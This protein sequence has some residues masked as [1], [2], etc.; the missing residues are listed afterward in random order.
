MANLQQ[1]K[2]HPSVIYN[3]I[4]EQSGSPEKALAELVMNSI[5]AG[6][7]NISIE[8]SS[9]KFKI[10][11]DG[12]G[13]KSL[14]EIETFFGTFGT[15]HQK[16]DAVYGQFRLGRGQSFAIAK[17]EWRSGL[18]GMSVDLICNSK[19]DVHGYSLH[20]FKD[21]LAGCEIEGEF[22]ES[23]HIFAG[24]QNAMVFDKL[25]ESSLDKYI[26]KPEFGIFNSD[27]FFERF[28]QNI[29]LLNN[30]NIT[31]NGKVV[32]GLL[33]TKNKVIKETETANYYLSNSNK[34]AIV[35]LNKGI[36]IGTLEFFVP[37]VI[38]F[39][40]SPNLNIA[41][42]QINAECPIYRNGR[43]E[44]Y[45]AIFEAWLNG[46]K[47]AKNVG[48]IVASSFEYYL[49]QFNKEFVNSLESLEDRI[50]FAKHYKVNKIGVNGYEEVSLY[51][52]IEYAK[53][54]KIYANNQEQNDE[55]SK[56]YLASIVEQM[57]L[58]TD[59]DD[60]PI[61]D[62]LMVDLNGSLTGV[63]DH[64]NNFGFHSLANWLGVNLHS[65]AEHFFYESVSDLSSNVVSRI[66]I[67]KE[68]KTFTNESIRISNLLK[69][70]S[71]NFDAND[72]FLKKNDEARQRLEDGLNAYQ[73]G[74]IELLANSSIEIMENS[75][76]SEN[77]KII[78]LITE[79][80]S[81]RK[82]Q[83]IFEFEGELY[84]V[85]DI[86]CMV[87]S[88]WMGNYL[89]YMLHENLAVMDNVYDTDEFNQGFHDKI[90]GAELA[91]IYD[92][93]HQV[94]LQVSEVLVKPT[95]RANQKSSTANI[96]SVWSEIL[97]SV[98]GIDKQ[99]DLSDILEKLKEINCT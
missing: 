36:Y 56:K 49:S 99:G 95:L 42:N 66:V 6:A 31:L 41:R 17:T 18:F 12:I 59:D 80:T 88:T 3:I 63:Y 57:N 84:M 72:N 79:T 96:R 81:Y 53:K 58:F 11:D 23:L 5:D 89:G 87:K 83:V 30:V 29:A 43:K 14:E 71:F 70:S 90:G 13:F 9:K 15:P 98:D 16:G 10:K 54:H 61:Q 50:K 25:F 92:G 78:P 8:L 26:A 62:Y 28:M 77:R 48:R 74:L 91:E 94:G 34:N 32:G 86:N 85:V 47:N 35:L 20:E 64:N 65:V 44:L 82:N 39:N 7:K 1:F 19:T 76:L 45:S 24:V 67:K 4:R 2:L 55:I 33:G 21:S 97:S 37:V 40:I 51:D 93:L 52:A 73:Q 68:K 69:D 22:Y 38:D 75:P 60:S 27:S 46:N